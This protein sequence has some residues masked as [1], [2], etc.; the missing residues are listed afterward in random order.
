MFERTPQ[1]NS[2][3]EDDQY[4]KLLSRSITSLRELI[5]LMV[6]HD[7]ETRRLSELL[8]IMLRQYKAAR[9]GCDDARA[10]ATAATEA[11]DVPM[12]VCPP[13]RD[14]IAFRRSR[15]PRAP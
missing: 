15:P 1:Q 3:I 12:P 6:E 7:R 10:R 5:V 11:A 8:C 13:P 4:V 9:K 2:S 14:R